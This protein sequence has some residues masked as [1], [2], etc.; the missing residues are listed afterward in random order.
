[1]GMLL[2][3]V[4][5][6]EE[7]V[8]L[9][10]LE[11]GIEVCGG[12]QAPDEGFEAGDRFVEVALGEER[13]GG[14]ALASRRGLGVGHAQPGRGVAEGGMKA[15]ERAVAELYLALDADQARGRQLSAD[16]FP[17]LRVH[18]AHE[19]RHMLEHSAPE[20]S[21]PGEC[22]LGRRAQPAGGELEGAQERAVP[23][24]LRVACERWE[25]LL[26]WLSSAPLRLCVRL[27]DISYRVGG[28]E[29]TNWAA[30]GRMAGMKSEML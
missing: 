8:N 27:F 24:R 15:Q 13:P 4:E 5:L 19:K 29:R 16:R 12:A 17:G 28:A 23:L 25:R 10:Q 11:G 18:L 1:M 26:C 3:L 6:T 22:A 7:E 2:S 20:E 21:E 30:E 14:L 9:R